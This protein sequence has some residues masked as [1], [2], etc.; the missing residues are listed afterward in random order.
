MP[1]SQDFLRYSLEQLAS[2]GGVVPRRMFGAFGLYHDG[3]FFGLI[4][5]DTLYLKVNDE[6]RGDYL[7]RG[8]KPFQPYPG[9]ARNPMGGYYEVPADVLEDPA[10]LTTWARKA[11]SVALQASR[12]SPAR[13][14]RRK[15]TED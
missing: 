15:P 6:T 3:V 1:V 12:G 10:E 11:C 13:R 4:D 7:S 9:Q 8:L 2:L 14:R 5:D